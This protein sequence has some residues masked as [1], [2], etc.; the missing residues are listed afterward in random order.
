VTEFDADEFKDWWEDARDKYDGDS[1]LC[2]LRAW[3]H[4]QQ[5]IDE[6]NKDVSGCIKLI[7]SQ[8]T[9]LNELNRKARLTK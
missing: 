1:Q 7:A 6:L 3:Q 2:A 8:E 4:Q 5:I 9:E